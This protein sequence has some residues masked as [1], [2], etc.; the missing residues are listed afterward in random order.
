MR[1][2]AILALFALLSCNKSDS[3]NQNQNQGQNQPQSSSNLPTLTSA[4]PAAQADI[5]TEEDF[6]DEAERDITP[7]NYEKQLGSLE[8]EIP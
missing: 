2:L 5:A 3:S 7:E 8:K 1:S 6:E 4:A